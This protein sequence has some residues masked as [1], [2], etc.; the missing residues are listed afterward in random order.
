MAFIILLF[1]IHHIIIIAKI[2]GK[3]KNFRPNDNELCFTE[4]RDLKKRVLI[5]PILFS[6][7]PSY[8]GLG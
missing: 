2:H 3:W 5:A 4:C 6:Y 1:S 8:L 7:P